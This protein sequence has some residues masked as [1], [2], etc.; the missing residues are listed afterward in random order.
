MKSTPTVGSRDVAIWCI[1]AVPKD[2]ARGLSFFSDDR[3]PINELIP[4]LSMH[5]IELLVVQ[6]LC[7]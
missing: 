1:Q 4:L 5:L 6:T 7:C 2:L 3:C